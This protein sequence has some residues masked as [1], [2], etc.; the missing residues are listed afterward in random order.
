MAGLK[1]PITK[2]KIGPKSVGASAKGQS[3]PSGVVA[4]GFGT[5]QPKG[6]PWAGPGKKK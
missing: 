2:G 4:G 5:G 6:R 3:S 1:K